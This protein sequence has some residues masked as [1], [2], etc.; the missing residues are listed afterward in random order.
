MLIRDTIHLDDLGDFDL[1]FERFTE[2]SVRIEMTWE[3]AERDVGFD[4]GWFCEGDLDTVTVEGVVMTGEAATV[5]V[6]GAKIAEKLIA[7]A[8]DKAVASADNGD[9][10]DWGR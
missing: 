3:S 2:A 10:A 6:G 7:A 5:A 8:C 4:G 9:Y 1:D